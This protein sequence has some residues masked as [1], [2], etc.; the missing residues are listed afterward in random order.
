V[1]TFMAMGG[2]SPEVALWLERYTPRSIPRSLWE[3]TLRPIVVPALIDLKP[4]GI[5]SGQIYAWALTRLLVWALGEHLPFDLETLLDPDTVERFCSEGLKDVRSRGQYRTYLRFIGPKLTKKAPW[6]PRPVPMG[7]RQVVRPHPPEELAAIRQDAYAQSSPT[8]RRSAVAIVAL[9]A[10]AGLDG[11]W[12]PK[13]RGTDVE[14]DGEAVLV[15]VGPPVPR[16]VPVLA[17]FEQDLLGLAEEA[18]DGLLIGGQSTSKNR[19][20][21]LARRFEVG[22]GHPALNASRLRATWLVHHLTVGTRLPELAAAAGL[23]GTGLFSD[24][25]AFVPALPEEEARRMLRGG[26]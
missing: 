25:L 19:A 20:S 21:A 13:V 22:H 4:K 15:R 23:Q 10:G 16:Q 17:E 11:R 12:S 5:A 26:P 6:E 3:A 1:T 8:R 14:R 18:G 24:L 7:H 9:G 2:L